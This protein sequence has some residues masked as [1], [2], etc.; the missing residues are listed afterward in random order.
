MLK[1]F[2]IYQIYFPISKKR[3]IGQTKNFEKRMKAHFKSGSLVCKALWKYDN[4]QVSILHTCKSRDE[5]NRIEIEEIRNFNSIVPNGYNLTH[6]G[7][8][9][10]TPRSEEWKQNHKKF[11]QGKQYAKGY[12]FTKEQLEKC[13][14]AHL[15]KKRP[16][17]SNFMKGNQFPN[18]NKN[19][20]VSKS[21]KQR[22]GEK[23]SGKALINIQIG[24]LKRDI[25]RLENKI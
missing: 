16:E 11:M 10:S 23:R 22:I 8:G 9:N 14:Q 18:G 21:N 19:P 12:K 25:G 3:Y 4:W 20:G 2:Y 1:Q 6:G 15:G 24:I 13:R 5:A 7:E 17:H